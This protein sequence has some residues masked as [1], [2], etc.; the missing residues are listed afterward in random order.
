[1]TASE[2]K[3]LQPFWDRSPRRVSR[4]HC[5]VSQYQK[6]KEIHKASSIKGWGSALHRFGI[7]TL[8]DATV[9]Y[10]QPANGYDT[11]GMAIISGNR[12]VEWLYRSGEE[13]P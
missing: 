2:R 6:G 4:L 7:Q 9:T 11:E 12:V 1:M 10:P 8:L 13:I 5:D 3:I